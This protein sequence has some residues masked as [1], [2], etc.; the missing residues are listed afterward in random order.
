MNRRAAGTQYEQKAIEYME[1]QGYGLLAKNFRCHFGEIDAVFCRD[2]VIIICEVKFRKDNS[3]GDPLEAVD[4]RKQKRICRTAMYF[5]MKKGYSMEQPCRFDVIGIHADGTVR[6]VE[7]AF[8]F[9]E[10]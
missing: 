4:R 1:G 8:E 3:C 9:I 7:N 6:H 10:G 2:G 5:Y